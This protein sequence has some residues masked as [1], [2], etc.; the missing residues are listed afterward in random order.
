MKSFKKI[1]T[2]IALLFI[3]LGLANCSSSPKVNNSS[4]KVELIAQSV[5]GSTN[6]TNYQTESD[7]VVSDKGKV[8]R[9][10][11][12]TANF[13]IERK[14]I[15][16][17]EKGDIQFR[18]T[19]SNKTGNVELKD[20]AYP[21]P[22]QE[23]YEMIDKFGK[24]LVVKDMPIGSIY[25]ISRVALPKEQVKVGDVWT[26]KV[27]WISEDTGWPFD[28]TIISKL[29]SWTDCDGLACAVITFDGEVQLPEDFP[30]KA[31]LK[32]TIKGEYQYSPVSYEI[33]WGMSESDEE[34]NIDTIE[35]NIKV[36]SKSCSYKIG[37]VK[38]CAKF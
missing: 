36:K 16:V 11:V 35:K 4:E 5:K 29:K 18:I 34:F 3:A 17:N 21:E 23:L 14:T 31:R 15:N 9:K 38:T 33:L 25:Y 2:N 8:T 20:L 37:Y 26:Y 7:V 24:H 30:L 6:L 27:R 32:S 19:T 22:G 28:L 12:D 10:Y 13:D 1:A